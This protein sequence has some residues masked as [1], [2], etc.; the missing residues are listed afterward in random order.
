MAYATVN[1]VQDRMTRTMSSEEEAVC[2]VLLDDAAAI[3]DAFAP[4]ANVDVKLVVSCRMVIR[5]LGDGTSIGIPLGA[6]Q[7]SMSGLGYSQ[8]WTLS[9]GANG[10]LYLS[11]LE[12]QMLG[13]GNKIGSYSPVE[14]L[15][16]TIEEEATP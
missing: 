5:A 1:D 11:K 6:T 16:P 14:A 10:E 7:G 12:K 15:V 13:L 3:I 9:N 2:S 8:S 4:S